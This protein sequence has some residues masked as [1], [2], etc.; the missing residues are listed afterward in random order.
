MFPRLVRR[1]NPPFLLHESHL[2]PVYDVV[3]RQGP[4]ILGNEFPP[5]AFHTHLLQTVPN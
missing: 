3:L 1:S 4:R 5:L 2:W